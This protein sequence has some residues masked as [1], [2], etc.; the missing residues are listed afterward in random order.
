MLTSFQVSW[1]GMT[2]VYITAEP[3]L[4]GMF[5]GM[6]GNYNLNPADDLRTSAGELT[7]SIFS[8]GNRLGK[9]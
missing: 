8:F 3:A 7:S 2:R 9:K 5:E 1:D 6:C 4:Q